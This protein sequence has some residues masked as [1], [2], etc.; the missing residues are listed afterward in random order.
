[1]KK[2]NLLLAVAV[3]ALVSCERE[4]LA[5]P[6][7]QEAVKD[8]V[9]GVEYIKGEAVVLFDEEMTSAVE[10][11]I[12][13]GSF[14]GTKASGFADLQ[15]SLGIESITR[16]FPDAGEFEARHREAG[17]HRWY[18]IT[19]SREVSRTKAEADFSQL[20]GVEYV[21]TPTE[22]RLNAFDYF[23]DKYAYYHWS[24]YNDGTLAKGFKKGADINV[25]PVWKEFTTGDPN[26]IVGV[27]DAGVQLDHPDLVGNMRADLSRSFVYGRE[28][29][30]DD[31]GSHGTHVS[32]TIAAMNNN[33]IGVCGIAGGDVKNGKPGVSVMNCQIFKT[34]GTSTLQ[35]NEVDAI[36][37]AAD[38]GAVILN[39]SWGTVFN[40]AASAEYAM[41]LFEE[42]KFNKDQKVAIDYFIQYAGFGLDG[43]QNGPM[44]GGLVI[45]AAGN[46]AFNAGVPAGY[47]KV[48]AV[49]ASGPTGK[50]AYYSNYGDWVD[51]CAPGG[52]DA[53]NYNYG[54][55]VS[56]V[57]TSDY[58][59][60]EGTSMACPHVAGVA[61]LLVSYLQGPGLTPDRIRELLLAGAKK[62]GVT[63]DH[64]PVG[65]MMDAYGSFKAITADK[66][67]MKSDHQGDI[68]LKSHESMKV[69]Y[70]ISNNDEGRF[71]VGFETS[72]SRITAKTSDTE[73]TVSVDAMQFDK[74][75]SGYF[76]VSVAKG[77][78]SFEISDTVKF[79]I[80]PNHA[81]K[82]GEKLEDRV[83]S[84]EKGAEVSIDISKCFTDEDG[85]KLT[86]EV[87]VGSGALKAKENGGVLTLTAADYGTSFVTI[88]ALDARKAKAEQ[89]FNVMLHDT[90]VSIDVY[91]NPVSKTLYV[92][93]A[94]AGKVSIK[95]SNQLGNVV[96]DQEKDGGPFAPIA[97]D[98]EKFQAGSYTVQAECSGKSVSTKIMKY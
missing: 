79:T 19:Y 21:G 46:D 13:S 90:A 89:T 49:G 66:P 11:A 8:P 78:P 17:L 25:V 60:M 53:V 4:N 85:E 40:D 69:K 45:F 14:V 41:K 5:V 23:N 71:V 44:A 67:S 15:Q 93:P 82:V 87:A 61:A 77:L 39:N 95:I 84:G 55:I 81:P 76:V 24:Y 38:H 34:E 65:P 73:V 62:D 64:G 72:D 57:R 88:T 3:L 16:R 74:E 36:V 10:E 22:N 54:M 70:T 97:I 96:Y 42:G 91:P 50:A 63:E 47:S 33:S 27:V 29:E 48:L 2:H 30:I 20:G 75:A 9:E 51:I 37:W 86:Y 12:A 35:G 52:D 94:A 18:K 7:I 83:I 31:T 28:G 43:K 59:L 6:E 56:T 80:L 58:A 92:R 98:V 68:T 1:M 26:V 32:G